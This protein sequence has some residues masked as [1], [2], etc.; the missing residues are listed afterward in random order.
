MYVWLLVFYQVK[1][2]STI[3]WELS[4]AGNK[5]KVLCKSMGDNYMVAWVMMLHGFIQLQGRI[6]CYDIASD[7]QVSIR[8]RMT[9]VVLLIQDL[10]Q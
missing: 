3:E 1:P 5:C 2:L 8:A 7:R 10:T 6:S 4:I 9:S